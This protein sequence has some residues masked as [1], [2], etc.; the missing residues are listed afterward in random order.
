VIVYRIDLTGK[1]ELLRKFRA[2]PYLLRRLT[3]E[4]AED[5]ARAVERR[6]KAIVPVKTG[7][8]RRSIRTAGAGGYWFAG[9]IGGDGSRTD[10]GRYA[11]YVEYGFRP[12]MRPAIEAEKQ[13]LP[14]RVAKVA[15]RLEIEV[16][17]A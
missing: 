3:A 17:A 12:F 4:V 5:S 1:S 8:L 10:P 2:S 9:V 6:A 15:R 11:P 14:A 16:K 13:Y 7:A